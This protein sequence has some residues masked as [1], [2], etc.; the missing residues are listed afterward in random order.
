[1]KLQLVKNAVTSKVGRQLLI[2]RKNSPTI[3]FAGGLVGVVASTVMACK[4]T[5]QLEGVLDQAEKDHEIADSL[6]HR[7]DSGRRQVTHAQIKRHT[8]G[9]II[10]LYAPS[11]GVGLVS[12]GALTGSHVTLNRRNA[13]LMAAYSALDRGFNEYRARV[14]E[15]FGEEKDRELRYDTETR[16][17][18][19][20]TA[21]GP[22]AIETKVAGPHARSVYSKIFDDTSPNWNRKPEYNRIFL[23]ATQNYATD[24]LHARGHLFLNEVYEMLGLP[25]TK[26]GSIVGWIVSKDGDNYVDFGIFNNIDDD[27]I[28]DF[29]NGYEPNILLDFNVDGIIYDKIKE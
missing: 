29:I 25:H 12:I 8:A 5:L 22:K 3:L 19:I 14:R 6:A 9:K 10:R 1:M 4:A 20:E 23:Q 21:D 24:K 7:D 17:E 16:T 28:R 27:H 13:A 26:A 18:V 15:E 11:V 2:G